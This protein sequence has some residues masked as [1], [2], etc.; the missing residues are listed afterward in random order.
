MLVSAR[1]IGLQAVQINNSSEA[2]TFAAEL[3]GILDSLQEVANARHDGRYLFAGTQNETRPYEDVSSETF[4]RG[5]TETGSVRIGE[6]GEIRT[7]YSGEAVFSTGSGGTTLIRGS[8]GAAGGSGT[9]SGHGLSQLQVQHTAT[10]FLGGSGIQ[11]G[12]SSAGGD[13]V[14]GQ[15]GTHRIE[16]TDISGSGASGTVSLNGGVPV[17]FS[18][19]DQNLKVTGPLGE[20]VFVDTSTIT[21]G[22]SGV[23]DLAA[24]GTL[25]LDGGQALVPIDFSDNQTLVDEF[26][27]VRH[28]NSQGITQTG[29]DT[30]QLEGNTDLFGALRSFRDDLLKYDEFTA[31]EWDKTVSAHLGALERATDHL[32]DVIGEQSVD[33]QTLDRLQDRGDELR[34]SAQKLLGE[35]QG[36]DFAEAVLQLQEEQNLTQYTFATLSGVFQVSV[37]DFLR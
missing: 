26:G 37:L 5:G 33:L 25:S 15:M 10:T 1:D 19:S 12:I 17:P 16:I 34:L 6:A 13:T 24:A 20:V 9:A 8:T 29:V 18:S 27:R 4:Y 22:Y 31:E 11:P 32:L 28:V 36:T 3:S 35:V 30:A 14:I 23:V 2:N 21:P 7:H